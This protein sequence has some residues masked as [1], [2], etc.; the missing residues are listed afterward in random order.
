MFPG[1]GRH[2]YGGQQSNYSNQQQGYDQGYNQGYGQGYGQEYNQGYDRPSG[3]PPPGKV[4]RPSGPPPGP[5]PGQGQYRPSGPPPSQQGQYNRPSGP[6][7]GQYGN[8]QTRGSETN[9]IM[10]I[11][12]VVVIIPV[13]QLIPN[14]L[15]L[16]ITIINIPIV[17]VGK[18]HC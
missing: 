3:P 14:L 16:R 6:P 2:T 1:Q 8:N 13:H 7:P 12:M 18:R 9:K 15:V 10:V 4:N 11:C 5:P 17:V